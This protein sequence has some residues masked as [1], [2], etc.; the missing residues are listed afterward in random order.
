MN[1]FLN[2]LGTDEN[3][4]AR[5]EPVIPALGGVHLTIHYMNG[6]GSLIN[7]MAYPE[8]RWTEQ[9]NLGAQSVKFGKVL[10]DFLLREFLAVTLWALAVPVAA[11]I[12]VLLTAESSRLELR[13]QKGDPRI[14]LAV[15]AWLIIRLL[16]IKPQTTIGA[17]GFL[18]SQIWILLP[19][20]NAFGVYPNIGCRICECMLGRISRQALLLSF[21]V[22]AIV[23]CVIWTFLSLF[24]QEGS[25]MSE[26]SIY[27]LRY[28]D[29][30]NKQV[31]LYFF[32]QELIAN[33]LF[34]VAIMVVPAMLRLN[35]F[36]E[37]ITI[38][39]LF[40]VYSI[41]VDWEGRGSTLAA[42][43]IIAQS[44]MLQRFRFQDY[45]RIL[46]QLLGNL[47][48]G[49]VMKNVFPDEPHL[50]MSK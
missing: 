48:A 19:I 49:L 10:N 43:V 31:F 27:G 32:V 28:E 11:L 14:A 41:G 6:S 39:V 38:L 24:W 8:Q 20:E 13:Q 26:S 25:L 18:F 44:I 1:P 2:S 7:K 15:L 17:P 30:S 33:S 50:S 46:A 47:L 23:P 36:P 9:Q 21:F 34:P 35:G 3:E 4:R 22:H 42:S 12:L 45:W 16:P 5:S 29:D 37:W 40:P